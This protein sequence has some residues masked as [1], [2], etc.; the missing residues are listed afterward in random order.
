MAKAKIMELD[1]VRAIAILA[2]LMIHGT[3][4]ASYYIPVGSRSQIFY[5]ALNK[6]SNFAVP[7]F[8]LLSGVVLFYRYSDK[9]SGR[10][11]LAFYG[12]R[13][14]FVV[15]PYLIWSFF[16]YIYNQWIVHY[17]FADV[18]L[19]G[20]DFLKKLQWADTSYHLYFI[21]IIVQ[22][23]LLFPVL[24]TLVRWRPVIGRYLIV[25]GLAVQVGYFLYHF[26][27]HPF[28]HRASLWFNY[29]A[30]F[31][32]GGYMGLNYEKIRQAERNLWWVFGLTVFIGYSLLM[33]FVLANQH[34]NFGQPIYELLFNGYAVCVAFSFLWIGRK[35]LK[36]SKVTSALTSIGAASFAIYFMHPAVLSWWRTAFVYPVGSLAYHA[37]TWVGFL[38]SLFVPWGIALL[39]KR[40]KGAWVLFGR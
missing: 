20:W 13:I 36:F 31:C 35:L 29:I 2:V 26:Y 10:E 23:Y 24:M 37:A 4:E 34:I 5:L 39:L 32:V 7:L 33:Y 3:S 28:E 25:I 11:A 21:I 12:K 15:I 17:S 16:Y 22:L 38:L 8:L 1:L 14:K 27:V 18:K 40:W 19:D 6:F 9:W 30:V